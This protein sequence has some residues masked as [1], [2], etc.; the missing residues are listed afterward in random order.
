MYDLGQMG[1]SLTR[2]AIVVDRQLGIGFAANAAALVAL[3]LGARR[4]DLAG[5]DLIDGAGRR[6]PGLLPVGLPILAGT[7]DEI[8]RTRDRAADVPDVLLIDFPAYGQTTND[9]AEV[10][11]LVADT[12]PDHLRYL[13]LALH[14]PSEVIRTLTRQFSLLR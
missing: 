2:T 6:H 14:G 4:P 13:G 1:A 12:P 9:Y 7:A 5:P 8:A 11:R 10:V 3:T